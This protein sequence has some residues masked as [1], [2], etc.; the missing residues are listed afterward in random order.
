MDL[1]RWALD[2]FL[3]SGNFPYH[4]ISD[5]PTSNFPTSN[6]LM[7][8]ALF[9]GTFDPFTLGHEDVVRRALPLF[10]EI[11]I[12]IGL[13]SSKQPMF[14]TEARLAWLREIFAGE[15]A[16]RVATYTGLTIAFCREIGARYMLRGLRTV[17]DFEYERA[18][19]E[20]NRTQAP[21]VETVFL[22][23]DSRY[24]AIS[25]TIVRDLV[26]Y[27]GDVTGAVPSAVLRGMRQLTVDN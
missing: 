25:S 21:E 10:D 2:V 17:A 14:P 24:A 4:C 18:I 12:G 1:G 3:G 5:F 15:P 22:A 27:G 7:R 23:C 9:P 16:V 26:R 20:M 11:V 19:A 8:I 6:E 13:N